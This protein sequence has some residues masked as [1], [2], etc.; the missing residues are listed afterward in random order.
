MAFLCTSDT[1]TTPTT[2]TVTTQI[3]AWYEDALKRLVAGGEAEVAD[4]PY[5]YYDPAQR[6][7]GLSPTEEAA[8]SQV[9]QAAGSYMPGLTAAY[10]SAMAGTR[11]LATP[12]YGGSP[13]PGL[14][15]YPGMQPPQH[16]TGEFRDA[17]PEEMAQVRE[18]NK[19]FDELMFNG[20]RAQPQGMPKD[21]PGGMAYAQD[22]GVNLSQYM[23]PY[24]QYVTDIAQ[25][26]AIRDYQKMVPQMG[27]Q[28]S[29]QGAFGGARYGVQ[30]AEN[31]RNLGQRLSD[32]ETKGL[33]SAFNAGTGLFEREAGRQ[34]QAAPIFQQI[35]ESAQKSGL[36]GL[37]AILKSQAIP[38]G[39]EQQL[40]DLQYQEKMREQGYGMGQ[41]K[42]L[43][44]IIRGVSPGGTT[45]TQGQT[46]TAQPSPLQTFGGLGLTGAGIYNLLYK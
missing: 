23:N 46:V 36:G 21:I 39:L 3:P 14:G 29:R 30:E 43:S 18:R 35:G 34:L 45:T 8:I 1:T 16:F 19:D 2:S 38:R 24:T 4:R 27:F 37:E 13:F 40:M 15:A 5:Q 17:S 31:L 10:G 44:G 26:E 25:R 32:I 28:A 7:A 33:E 9:P 22:A 42:D 41:L 12:G 20:P 11:S 6:V